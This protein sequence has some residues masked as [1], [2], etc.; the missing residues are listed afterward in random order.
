V[1]GKVPRKKSPKNLGFCE[2]QTSRL[3]NGRKAARNIAKQMLNTPTLAVRNF[4]QW[5]AGG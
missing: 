1:A 5:A 3:T 2:A 4:T